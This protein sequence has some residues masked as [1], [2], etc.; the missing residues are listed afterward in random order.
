MS[1]GLVVL[2]DVDNT[3]LDNDLVR[4]R[5]AG[6][7]AA[8]LGDEYAARFWRIYEHVRAETG[9]VDFPR[10][11][12]RFHA[13]C[14]EAG[15][16]GALSALL[17]EF[18]FQQCLFPDTVE[19]IRHVSAFATPVILSDGDQM[20]QRYKIRAAGLE[21]AVA[22][23]VLVYAHKE[24]NLDDVRKRFPA[25]HYAMVDDKARILAALKERMGRE[26]TTVMVCQGKYA[27]DPEHHRYPEPDVTIQD[28][29]GLLA[30]TAEGIVGAASV[31][32]AD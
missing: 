13:G 16:E 10:T 20:F 32:G 19:A 17:Y 21:E 24:Q 12:E 29:G 25:G 27:H 31:K 7:I 14:P 11:V 5:L 6:D 9:L 8:L 23:N 26:L 3:L 1:S 28:I 18:P 15:S 2:L 4:S 22:G 30:L